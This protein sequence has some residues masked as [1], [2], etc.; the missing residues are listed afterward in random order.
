MN[1]KPVAW[2]LSKPSGEIGM[3]TTLQ[4]HRSKGLITRATL[5]LAKIL[6]E[7]GIFPF[8]VAEDVNINSTRIMQRQ[9][10]EKEVKFMYNIY[11]KSRKQTL[12]PNA[13]NKISC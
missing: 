12:G 8:G 7:K 3:G 4:E 9:G 1:S 10:F 5:N 11:E 6:L 2:A 13:I